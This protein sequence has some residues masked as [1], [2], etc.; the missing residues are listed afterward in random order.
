MHI[1]FARLDLSLRRRSLIGYS[2]GLAIYVLVVVAIDPAFKSS[3]ELDNFVKGAAGIAALFGISGSLT[4]PAGWVNANVSA[5]FFPLVMLLV[6]IGYGAAAIA[7]QD[8]D[9]TLGLAATLPVRRDTIVFAKAGVMAALGFVLAVAVV[10]CL[11]F[12]PAFQLTVDAGN[13]VATCAAVL[14]MGIDF[15]LIAMAIGAITGRRGTAIGVASALA[16]ASYL[17]SSLAP[18]IDWLH[19]ARYASL[20]FWSVGNDQIATGMSLVDWGVLAGTGLAAL[21]AAVLAFRRLD[22]Q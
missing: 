12:G 6:T 15:G 14:L 18:V 4:S 10:A 1:E 2:L 5:N 8:E 17:I 11:L 9:G 22:L 19:P 7:G 16:A 3:T 20:L 13:A 21:G